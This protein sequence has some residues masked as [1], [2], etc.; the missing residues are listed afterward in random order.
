MATQT[1]H[2]IDVAERIAT[3]LKGK[4]GDSIFRIMLF[5][6]RAKGI[7]KPFSDYD[8]LIVVENRTPDIIDA[9]YEVVYDYELLN[10]IDISMKIYSTEAYRRGVEAGIPFLKS[11]EES[12]IPL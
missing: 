3:I 9:I 5:G 11:V 4:F 7:A 2:E 6:S 10:D 12:G 1:N 8:L